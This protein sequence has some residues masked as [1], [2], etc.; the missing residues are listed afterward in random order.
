MS[1]RSRQYHCSFCL[2]AVF[3]LMF[4]A[5]LEA[6][7][8]DTL[9]AREMIDRCEHLIRGKSN[10]GIYEMTIVTPHWQ[11]SMTMRY[12]DKERKKMFIHITSPP[13]EKNVT[14]LRD[15]NNMWQYIPKVERVIKIPPSMMMQSWMGSD[16]TN[17]D[18]VK[19]S[20]ILHDYEHRLMGL[21]E[22]DG[23]ELYEIELIAKPDAPVVW[24]RIV[25]LVRKIDYLPLREDYYNENGELKRTMHF[26]EIRKMHDRV[27]PTLMEMRNHA[28]PGRRTQIRI[29]EAIY[30]E[31]ISEDVFT[32]RNLKIEGR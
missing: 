28:K 9:S 20:S 25:F 30:D 11:R 10:Y 6:A 4:V 5:D 17:D 1:K 16:F 18:L 27:V 15:G 12:W 32:I 19:E 7:S 13:K 31:P 3:L 2:L 14:F 23:E 26:S 29:I 24:G 8:A 22:L 21:K